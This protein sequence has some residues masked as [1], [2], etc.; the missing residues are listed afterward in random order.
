MTTQKAN[1]TSISFLNISVKLCIQNDLE[2]K[3]SDSEAY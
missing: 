1:Y 3:E 2:G